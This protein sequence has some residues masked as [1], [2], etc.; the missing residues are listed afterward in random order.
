MSDDLQ[1][2]SDHS[3]CK[4]RNIFVCNIRSILSFDHD[5]SANF[6]ATFRLN[7][8]TFGLDIEA[9]G[10]SVEIFGAK[11]EI[12]GFEIASYGLCFETHGT[13]NETFVLE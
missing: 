8:G 12:Y 10:L 3:K 13:E 9:N 4:M 2:D 6:Y 7:V 11:N 1:L 5:K